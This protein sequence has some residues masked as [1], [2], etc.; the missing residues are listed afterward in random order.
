[1]TLIC[2]FRQHFHSCWRLIHFILVIGC[3]RSWC[4]PWDVVAA[5]AGEVKDLFTSHVK[6]QAVP[7]CWCRVTEV[8]SL[9]CLIVIGSAVYRLHVMREQAHHAVNPKTHVWRTHILEYKCSE[10]RYFP[11]TATRPLLFRFSFNIGILSHEP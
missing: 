6:L 8:A 7:W 3:S 11:I 1:V 9:F 2:L 5:Y 4:P 10:I